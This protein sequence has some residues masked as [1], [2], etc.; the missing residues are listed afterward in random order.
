[1]RSL[2]KQYEKRTAHMGMKQLISEGIAFNV[3]MRDSNILLTI[4]N[5]DFD[6]ATAIHARFEST[7]DNALADAWRIC[8]NST[9]DYD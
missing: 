1:M 9:D 6:K 2:A 8:A 7:I 5:T 4:L 3:N